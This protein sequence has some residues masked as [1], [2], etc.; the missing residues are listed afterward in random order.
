[1]QSIRETYGEIDPGDFACFKSIKMKYSVVEKIDYN[2]S[3]DQRIFR[4][5]S[6]YLLLE[7]TYTNKPDKVTEL[8]ITFS[9][10]I[11]IIKEKLPIALDYEINR[12]STS[13]NITIYDSEFINNTPIELY[14][15]F[16]SMSQIHDA[17]REKRVIINNVYINQVETKEN[18]FI[19]LFQEVLQRE[20]L[21]LH[22][23]F[24]NILTSTT[25]AFSLILQNKD[26]SAKYYIRIFSKQQLTDG[27]DDTTEE[28]LIAC[29]EFASL[30]QSIEVKCNGNGLKECPLYYQAKLYNDNNEVGCTDETYYSSSNFILFPNSSIVNPEPNADEPE[31]NS[32]Q[33]SPQSNSTRNS[34]GADDV[35]IICSALI[36]GGGIIGVMI[37]CFIK[38]WLRV[39]VINAEFISKK[40]E[41][42]QRIEKAD[43]ASRKV[44]SIEKKFSIDE[45]CQ[46]NLSSKRS[47]TAI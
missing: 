10:G 15:R 18:C 47:N 33:I 24:N 32:N 22:I 42:H 17:D 25:A 14:V 37:F 23:A 31:S 19:S 9:K 2:V 8:T 6:G 35:V 28:D 20:K 4:E 43:K 21:T 29:E 39:K 45:D 40:R 7:L 44:V 34:I 38:I 46:M 3:K 5:D 30:Y 26:P 27:D 11:A 16:Y 13:T 1:M 41:Q 12:N 36:V